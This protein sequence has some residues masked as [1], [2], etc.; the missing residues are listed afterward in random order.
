MS[1]SSL[2]S[3]ERGE[4]AL[5]AG[6]LY[7]TRCPV[8]TPSGLAVALGSLGEALGEGH[9]VDLRALQDV[10]DP[11]LRRHHFDHGIVGLVRDGGNIPAIWARA[12]G[13]PTRLLGLTWLNEVQAVVTDA[14]SPVA[15][16]ADLVG[17]RVAIPAAS[18][19]I[20]DIRRATALR[21]FERT[22]ATGDLGLD[23]VVQV[24]VP[25]PELTGPARDG[26]GENFDPD[27]DLLERG[28][29]DAV[30]VKG[31]GGFA[32]I[33][34]RGLRTVLRLDEQPD[35]FA[36]IN[37]GTPRTVTARQ[38]LIDGRPDL[39]ETYL[40]VLSSA[41]R[42]VD[43]D[44]DELWRVLAGETHQ[45]PAAAKA[46]YGAAGA[47]SLVPSLS[48]L[49]LDALQQQADF[50]LE[51]DFIPRRVDVDEWALD[52]EAGDE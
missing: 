45:D 16:I 34:D 10:E 35:P 14:D 15:T 21:G 11:A 51:H 9:G 6:V 52:L 4:T 39:V 19:S 33:R 31:A 25:T 48:R 22:L 2:Q 47:D 17:K 3:V 7:Y 44:R 30:F 36:R 40:A 41:Q 49:R 18:G 12:N 13:V 24:G 5:D 27:L 43:G 20:V 37:N 32:A 26:S 50:L 38:E 42:S 1:G 28:E 29:V 8:P 46:A 23:Q